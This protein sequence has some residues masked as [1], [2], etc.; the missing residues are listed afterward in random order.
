MAAS[1]G[2]TARPGPARNSSLR[3]PHLGGVI[4]NRRYIQTAAEVAG[5]FVDP[6]LI[7]EVHKRD[8]PRSSFARTSSDAAVAFGDF[9]DS[10]RNLLTY[11][12]G[13]WGNG[14]PLPFLAGERRSPSLHDRCGWMRG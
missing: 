9:G 3:Q 13:M 4:S 1:E 7:R 6:I 2:V 10:C 12:G 5:S 11:C 14:V 8:R